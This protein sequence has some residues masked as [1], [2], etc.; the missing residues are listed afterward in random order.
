LLAGTETV[1]C[2]TETATGELAGVEHVYSLALDGGKSWRPNPNLI[3]VSQA[4]C[5]LHG[6][7]GRLY[8]GTGLN[9]DVFVSQGSRPSSAI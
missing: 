8:V 2:L 3:G 1:F 5:L 4:F 9:G 7:D 6:S